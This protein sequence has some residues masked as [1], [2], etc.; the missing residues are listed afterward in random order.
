MAFF[1]II[2]MYIVAMIY[3]AVIHTLIIIPQYV[4]VFSIF[5]FALMSPALLLLLGAIYL[6]YELIKL[7]RFWDE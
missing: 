5:W 3:G 4:E 6:S 2:L 7:H 1:I